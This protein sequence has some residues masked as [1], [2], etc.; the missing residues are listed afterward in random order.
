MVGEAIAAFLVE[1]GIPP[2]VTAAELVDRPRPGGDTAGGRTMS[3]HILTAELAPE[4]VEWL[5]ILI[6]KYQRLRAESGIP[7]DDRDA[8]AEMLDSREALADH[9]DGVASP[10]VR[11]PGG[12][13]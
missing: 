7:E 10:A 11:G 6:D 1:S 8:A 5:R 4:H 13:P 3:N 12:V 2:V 9:L